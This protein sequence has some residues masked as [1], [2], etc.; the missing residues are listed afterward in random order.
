MAIFDLLSIIDTY[1]YTF[2]IYINSRKTYNTCLTFTFSL[3]TYALFFLVLY[4]QQE[5]F[6]YKTNPNISYFKQRDLKLKDVPAL[7][8]NALP[9]Y[10]DFSIN[11]EKYKQKIFEHL[12]TIVSLEMSIYKKGLKY[13]FGNKLDLSQC[14]PDDINYFNSSLT[15]P[16]EFNISDKQ[17]YC[18]KDNNFNALTKH[19]FNGFD[20]SLS[21]EFTKC[22]AEDDAG[23]CIY[24]EEFN[25]YIDKEGVNIGVTF[26]STQVDLNSY[27]KPFKNDIIKFSND[28]WVKGAKVTLYP[29]TVVDIGDQLFTKESQQTKLTYKIA[30]NVRVESL[31]K[32]TFDCKSSV[33]VYKRQFKTLSAGL[34][35]TLAIMKIVVWLF[36]L[37]LKFY[38]KNNIDNIFINDNFEY[39]E[40]AG[41]VN[42]SQIS[43][44][45][46]EREFKVK[47][48]EKAAVGKSGIKSKCFSFG[49]C[50]LLK[51]KVK[52]CFKRRLTKKENFYEI[53]L[54][55]I[56]RSLSVENILKNT[57]DFKRFKYYVLSNEEYCALR[58]IKTVI[59]SDSERRDK[60]NTQNKC[61]QFTDFS[62]I[63]DNYT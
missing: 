3:I 1:G 19:D 11:S 2:N 59:Y 9:I 13:S 31:Y 27:S 8:N 56:F 39:Q 37:I 38:C 52:N 41:Q 61:F 55:N 18:L 33:D 44:N 10:V 47:L 25:N 30:E 4:Y 23:S 5:D 54:N 40:S 43:I 17:L 35:S 49:L 57:Y 32:I 51:Y 46:N 29:I 16:D 63:S 50:E 36:S 45:S 20:F 26:L 7:D 15:E 21:L 62:I 22:Q 24:D 14:T 34:A 12:Y 58:N 28:F 42:N 53:A 48:L 60:E 6:L